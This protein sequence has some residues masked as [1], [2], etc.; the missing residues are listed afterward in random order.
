MKGAFQIASVKGIR[1]FIHWTFFI[2]FIWIAYSRISANGTVTDVLHEIVFMLSLFFC[3]LLHELGHALAAAK[4]NIKTR[5]I[6]L[7]PIGGVARLEKM[8]E[9]PK[10]ELVVAIAGPLVN[11]AI[12]GVLLIVIYMGKGMPIAFDMEDYSANGFAVNMMLV[13]ISL[14][15]FNLIPAFPMDGGR[16]FRALLAMKWSRVR[17]TQIAAAVGQSIAVLFIAAGLFFNPFLILI[18]VFVFFGAQTENKMIQQQ[19]VFKNVT[20]KQAMISTY[21]ALSDSSTYQ[22]G[23]NALLSGYVT[24]FLVLSGAEVIGYVTRDELLKGYAEYGPDTLISHSTR[25][26]A[27]AVTENDALDKVWMKMMESDLPLV[28]VYSDGVVTGI[29]SKENVSELMALHLLKAQRG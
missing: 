13:N 16:V 18:G 23:V 5:D 1:I 17:A 3:V 19:S 21:T 15:V 6:T 12:V 8:P 11:V 26:V 28:P 29:L 27:Y 22:E 24:D 9:D 7:L 4:Y 2:L 20:V 10:Q 25:K 14:I